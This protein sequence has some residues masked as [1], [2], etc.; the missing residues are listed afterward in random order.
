MA[1]AAA[2]QILIQMMATIINSRKRKRAASREQIIYA[3]IDERDRSR[4]EYLNNKIWKNDT[5]CLNML[6]L[7]R[8]AFFDF[9]KFLKIV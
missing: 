1:Y 6:R 2:A 8:D 4:I 5:T 9:A 7:R 3:P